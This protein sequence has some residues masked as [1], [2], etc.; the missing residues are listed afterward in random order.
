MSKG[1]N[2]G[3]CLRI[4]EYAKLEGTDTVLVLKHF[5]SYF[6]SLLSDIGETRS[7]K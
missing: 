7:F 6:T 4:T 5:Y 1:V 3:Y 2:V